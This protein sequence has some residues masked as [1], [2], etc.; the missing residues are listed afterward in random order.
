MST[1]THYRVKPEH[2][3]AEI[4]PTG[5]ISH[6]N[7]DYIQNLIDKLKINIIKLNES[8]IEFDII[9]IDASIAN[10]L[11][12]ILL[13]EVPTIAIEHVWIAVNTSI[14]QDEVLAHRIGLIPL[15]VDPNK[16]DYVVNEEETDK[17]TLVFHFD[18]ECTTVISNSGKS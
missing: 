2:Q 15:K 17:D 7:S 1:F 8:D 4:L 16:L 12:R 5:N 6:Q 14:I 18:V 3:I 10:A 13:A 9:G 11:R